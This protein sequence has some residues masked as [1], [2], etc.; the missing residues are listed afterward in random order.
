MYMTI[1]PWILWI[2]GWSNLIFNMFQL[3]GSTTR[4]PK[5]P[6]MKD[7]SYIT[8]LGGWDVSTINPIRSGGVWTL[9]DSIICRDLSH[10]WSQLLGWSKVHH[11]DP[12]RDLKS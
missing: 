3:S 12:R 10:P 7:I 5:D 11:S 9:R 4:Y 6:G 8:I 1:V 2:I